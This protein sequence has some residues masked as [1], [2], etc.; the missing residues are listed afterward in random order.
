[1]VYLGRK[2]DLPG[3]ARQSP[4]RPPAIRC[5]V[6]PSPL[7]VHDWNGGSNASVRGTTGARSLID[8][9]CC[10]VHAQVV[11]A[12][13]GGALGVSGRRG[14]GGDYDH[15]VTGVAGVAGGARWAL[16]GSPHPAGGGRGIVAL[17]GPRLRAGGAGVLQLA[18]TGGDADQQPGCQAQIATQA[19]ESSEGGQP[20]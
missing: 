1:M 11:P 10:S 7:S 2:R 4:F 8:R 5:C 9:E 18:G 20:G 13:P 19:L 15:A 16:A 3:E 12:A 17:D 14:G 6:W